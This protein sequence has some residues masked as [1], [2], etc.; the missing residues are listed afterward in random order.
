[1]RPRSSSNR[2]SNSSRSQV[3]L[4][5]VIYGVFCAGTA[6]TF[7]KTRDALGELLFFVLNL[8]FFLLSRYCRRRSFV[9]SLLLR[10]MRTYADGNKNIAGCYC[11]RRNYQDYIFID[12]TSRGLWNH[13][14]GPVWRHFHFSQERLFDVARW[15]RS[16]FLWGASCN[17]KGWLRQKRP[18]RLLLMKDSNF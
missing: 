6:K 7:A 8:L 18:P 1:M 10:H 17:L 13:Y 2:A 15:L 9:R 3:T 16:L 14:R 4:K 12:L 11:R 5:L